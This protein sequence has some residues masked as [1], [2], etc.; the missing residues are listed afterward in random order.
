MTVTAGS[1]DFRFPASLRL[2]AVSETKPSEFELPKLHATCSTLA[3]WENPPTQT[4]PWLPLLST[5][6]LPLITF[7]RHRTI[8]QHWQLHQVSQQKIRRVAFQSMGTDP[9]GDAASP[10]TGIAAGLD[11][12]F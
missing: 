11:I 12:R 5:H 4:V 1:A 9:V 7:C 2:V 6:C 8:Q 10:H 3:R